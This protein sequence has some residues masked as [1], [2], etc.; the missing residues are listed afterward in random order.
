MFTNALH[1]FLEHDTDERQHVFQR[2]GQKQYKKQQNPD[3]KMKQAN[4]KRLQK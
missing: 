3:K 4:M 1:I 2:I